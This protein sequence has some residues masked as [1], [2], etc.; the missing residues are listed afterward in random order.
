MRVRTVSPFAQPIQIVQLESSAGL[1]M[2]TIVDLFLREATL[3][4]FSLM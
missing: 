2:R 4:R 1:L 3:T